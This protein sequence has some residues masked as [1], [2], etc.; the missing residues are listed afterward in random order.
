MNVYYSNSLISL[1]VNEEE[2]IVRQMQRRN[3]FLS[4]A[5]KRAKAEKGSDIRSYLREK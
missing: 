2:A 1:N 3:I 4:N 5:H